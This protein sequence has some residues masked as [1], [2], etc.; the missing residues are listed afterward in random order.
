MDDDRSVDRHPHDESDNGDARVRDDA[1]LVLALDAA[2]AAADVIRSFTGRP[3]DVRHKSPNQPLTAADLAAD[4][5][6]RE[7]LHG[8]RPDY[9]WLSEETTDSPDRLDRS[10]VWI[11]DPIDGTRSFI[12]GRPE[13][14]ISIG[15]A[16]NGVPRVGVILNPA[17]REIFYAVRGEGAWWRDEQGGAPR[18]L[19][20]E[21]EAGAELVASRSDLQARWL[22]EIGRGWTLRPLGSTAYKLALVAAGRAAGYVTRGRRSEWD[23]CAGVLLIEE[24]GA[25]ITDS[26]GAAI[27]FNRRDTDVSGVVAAPDPLHAQL[28]ARGGG[29]SRGSA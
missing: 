20:A 8:G 23:L 2:R 22:Q 13:Y 12:A 16:V 9:G 6:L 10:A 3:L 25:R 18:R 28:L 29:N 26:T 27:P 19:R 17:T 21:P 14:S 11:V 5:L 24:A 15:L 1:D 7:R 4:A